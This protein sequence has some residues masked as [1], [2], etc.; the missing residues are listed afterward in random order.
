MQIFLQLLL[1]C[2]LAAHY[3]CSVPLNLRTVMFALA[4]HHLEHSP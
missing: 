1:P 2:G 3:K 4:I